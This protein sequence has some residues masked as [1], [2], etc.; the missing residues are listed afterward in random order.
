MMRGIASAGAGAAAAG[1]RR[2]LRRR[3]STGPSSTDSSST[4]SAEKWVVTAVTARASCCAGIEAGGGARAGARDGAG[5]G[6]EAGA[7]GDGSGATGARSRTARADKAGRAAAS[8]A[9]AAALSWSS[10]RFSLAA[11]FRA[12]ASAFAARCA[13]RRRASISCLAACFAAAAA[14][15]ASSSSSSFS[16]HAPGSAPRRRAWRRKRRYAAAPWSSP[17]RADPSRPYSVVAEAERKGVEALRAAEAVTPAVAVRAGA[18]GVEGHGQAQQVVHHAL[19]AAVRA[20]AVLP[21]SRQPRRVVQLEAQRLL[22]GFDGCS[23]AGA[24]QRLQVLARPPAAAKQAAEQP[25]G[26]AARAA[27]RAGSATRRAT[28][29]IARVQSGLGGKKPPVRSCSSC[30][31]ACRRR[32]HGV[33]GA[34]DARTRVYTFAAPIKA[35][36][37]GASQIPLPSLRA[38]A[39]RST[40]RLHRHRTGRASSSRPRLLR[41]ARPSRP[42]SAG[43]HDRQATHARRREHERQRAPASLGQLL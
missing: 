19:F 17:R 2:R 43:Q 40:R 1:A 11:C 41:G 28:A 21:R 24:V 22:I 6:A 7:G 26:R 14:A 42:P 8:A 12:A 25:H 3:R 36:G 31:A 33:D 5:A 32:R 37:R 35:C 27:A 23:G 18:L 4:C 10:R 13:A 16:A 39:Y 30:A 29:P 15:T 9:A 20:G 34:A 38:D